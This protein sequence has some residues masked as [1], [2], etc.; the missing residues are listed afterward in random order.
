MFAFDNWIE[1]IYRLALDLFLKW[2]NHAFKIIGGSFSLY[3]SIQALITLLVLSNMINENTRYYS[4]GEILFPAV[5][6][7][8]LIQS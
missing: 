1:K 8:I 4:T 6:L 3:H 5:F 7:F 2:K